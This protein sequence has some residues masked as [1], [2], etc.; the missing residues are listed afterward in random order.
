[1]LGMSEAA[2]TSF[3]FSLCR[4]DK[5]VRRGCSLSAR[6][7]AGEEPQLPAKDNSAQR[8]FGRVVQKPNM[9]SVEGAGEAR[10]APEHVLNGFS[11]RRDRGF[12]DVRLR[13]PL[14]ARSVELTDQPHDKHLLMSNPRLVVGGL[15]SGD[16]EF[17]HHVRAPGAIRWWVSVQGVDV[18]GGGVK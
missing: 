4:D 15:G 18:I 16:R 9:S 12:C 13:R 8:P 6:I 10:P 14:T 11:R 17:A 3:I 5:A 2:S 7:G 1:M